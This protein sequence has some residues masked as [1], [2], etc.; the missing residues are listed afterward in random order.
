MSLAQDD[1]T[2]LPEDGASDDD[3]S[4]DDE[5]LMVN[6]SKRKS[7]FQ[8]IPEELDRID[9]RDRVLTKYTDHHVSA[10]AQTDS[11]AIDCQYFTPDE[12][13][14]P[15]K[16]SE[17]GQSDPGFNRRSRRGLLRTCRRWLSP[18]RQTKRTG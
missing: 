16:S 9:P 7:R 11:N 2:P 8:L 4:D 13:Y 17:M 14:A 10:S 18:S 5:L 1:A 3:S 6:G 12:N 15:S